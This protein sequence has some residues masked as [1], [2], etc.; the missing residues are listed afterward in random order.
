MC[1]AAARTSGSRRS[2]GTTVTPPFSNMVSRCSGQWPGVEGLP[3][4][5]PRVAWL[6]SCSSSASAERECAVEVCG[7]GIAGQVCEEPGR[8]RFRPN[9]VLGDKAYS[10]RAIRSHLR[11]RGIEAMIAEQTTRS[12][13]RFGG[14]PRWPPVGFDDNTHK[15]RHVCTILRHPQAVARDLH[16]LRL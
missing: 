1:S 15:C 10:S 6:H 8:P 14:Q 2:L 3:Q 7:V 11:L 13:T 16:S 12:V 9:A 5:Q 4:V